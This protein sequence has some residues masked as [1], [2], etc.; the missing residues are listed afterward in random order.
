[1]TREFTTRP[2]HRSETFCENGGLKQNADVQPGIRISRMGE[3][4]GEVLSNRKLD[5]PAL[6]A[7]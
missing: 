1:M 5:R 2:Y 7:R 3:P 6:V 4:F